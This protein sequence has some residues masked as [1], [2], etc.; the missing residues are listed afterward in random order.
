LQSKEPK[1]YDNKRN[2]A[3]LARNFYPRNISLD[4][5]KS[6]TVYDLKAPLLTSAGTYSTMKVAGVESD[7]EIPCKV[8]HKRDNA[9]A[10]LI[11]P[12]EETEESGT[13]NACKMTDASTKD[14][15]MEK[16]NM[17]FLVVLGLRVLLAKSIT[18]NIIMSA[19]LFL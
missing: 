18:L 15:K 7:A 3:C 8:T 14:V 11:L 9:T 17:L 4:V 5:P 2:M 6:D 10:S 12:G 19:V 16:E 13:V 1:Q